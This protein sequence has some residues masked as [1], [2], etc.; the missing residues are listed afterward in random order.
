[1]SVWLRG[2][3]T[4][5]L[6]CNSDVMKLQRRVAYYEMFNLAERKCDKFIP[7]HIP[8]GGLAH[9]NLAFATIT[10]DF[11]MSE[12]DADIVTRA[13]HLKD[14]FDG[15]RVNIAIGGW[16]FNDGDTAHIWS[17][18]VADYENMQT[19]LTPW[20]PT[21]TNMVSMELTWI[22]NMLLLKTVAA[23]MKIMTTM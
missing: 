17:G 14:R 4:T 21:L 20:L 2:G 10:E 23:W 9:L 1:M 22:G 7:E 11:E 15:L 13:A 6:R 8:A 18:L 16:A 5:K 12:E 19:S 3:Q